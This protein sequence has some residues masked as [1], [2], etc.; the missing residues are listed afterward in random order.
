MTRTKKRVASATARISI[1]LPTA[2]FLLPIGILAS[3]ALGA[4]SVHA[5][6]NQPANAALADIMRRTADLASSSTAI[7][8]AAVGLETFSDQAVPVAATVGLVRLSTPATRPDPSALEGTSLTGWLE[9]D[10]VALPDTADEVSIVRY[11]ARVPGTLD[12]VALLTFVAPAS[13]P[14]WELE[15]RFGAIARTLTLAA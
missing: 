15:D 4:D 11:F 9:R 3:R 6:A 10:R 7:A 13:V 2:W 8:L 5:S 12:V 1:A 14:D